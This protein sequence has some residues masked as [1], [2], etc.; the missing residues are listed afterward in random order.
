VSDSNTFFFLGNFPSARTKLHIVFYFHNKLG[1][2]SGHIRAF[3]TSNWTLGEANE[4]SRTFSPSFER[5]GKPILVV[6][7]S[8]I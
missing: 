4:I 1:K 5:E 6:R 2:H 8:K 3:G 7:E